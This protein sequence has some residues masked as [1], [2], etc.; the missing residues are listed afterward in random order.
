M[1]HGV[2]AREQLPFLLERLRE[3]IGARRRTEDRR[4][5][6]L[7]EHDHE[8]V[9]DRGQL[10]RHVR[11]RRGAAFAGFRAAFPFA[12]ALLGR[13]RAGARFRARGDGRGGRGRHFGGRRFRFRRFRSR[14]RRFRARGG[15]GRRRLR[16]RREDELQVRPGVG[17]LGAGDAAAGCGTEQRSEAHER[18]HQQRAHGDRGQPQGCPRGRGGCRGL[19]G[20]VGRVGTAPAALDPAFAGAPLERLQ[21]RPRL[22]GTCAAEQAVALVGGQR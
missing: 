17:R 8:D 7:R 15:G 4:V 21:L 19:R 14:R 13:C 18:S 2:P 10:A 16:A 3:V 1:R 11:G 20:R 9:L 6:L 12:G 22:R 5:G